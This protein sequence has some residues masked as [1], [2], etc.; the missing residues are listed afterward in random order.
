MK[1]P[2][3]DQNGKKTGEVELPAHLF[4]SKVNPSLVHSALVRQHANARI[5]SAH[6]LRRGEVTRSTRKIMR[7]KGSGKARKGD[8]GSPILRGGGA[9]WGPRNTKNYTKEMPKKQRRLALASM[10]SK[11]A[12]SSK[13]IAL[14]SFALDVPNT[15]EFEKL[16]NALPEGKSLLVVHNRNE[17]LARSSRNLKFVKPLL[18][19]LLNPHDLTKFDRILF[20]KSALEEAEKIF[21]IEPSKRKAETA[22]KKPIKK[23]SPK[24]VLKTDPSTS[25]GQGEEDAGV[26]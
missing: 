20:E 26:V 24:K 10:L 16:L 18:V 2:I 9:A 13:I 23:A 8:S 11:K 25:S 6:T 19:N 4:N 3:Y 22:E 21:K 14:E 17:C 1:A 5:S 15:K 12:K 7:Q